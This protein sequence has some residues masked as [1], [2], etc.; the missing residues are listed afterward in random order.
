[1]WGRMSNM[2]Q[3]VQGDTPTRDGGAGAQQV[4]R[5]ANCSVFAVFVPFFRYE[6]DS[7]FF[8]CF[9]TFFLFY[10]FIIIFF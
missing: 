10:F 8:V 4:N 9:V 3:N 6:H 1:M 2:M 7:T 5:D